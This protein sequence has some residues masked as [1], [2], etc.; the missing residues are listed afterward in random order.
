MDL[1]NK[2]LLAAIAA[3][4]RGGIKDGFPQDH[5]SILAQ[6]N[7]HNVS[8]N[9]INEYLENLSA[10]RDEKTVELDTLNAKLNEKE[11]KIARL[12]SQ[13]QEAQEKFDKDTIDLVAQDEAERERI[14]KQLTDHENSCARE[15]EKLKKEK[16]ALEKKIPLI[17]SEL[18][19][20]SA[21]IEILYEHIKK[22]N[23]ERDPKGTSIGG[24]G[25]RRY[26]RKR[27]KR[28]R[29][30][31]LYSKTA[32]KKRSPIKSSKRSYKNLKKKSR[33]IVFRH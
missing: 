11:G 18:N 12:N 28:Y 13:I 24:G 33:K 5:D 4:R 21:L 29:G 9:A 26:K 8:L 6:I 10:R 27:S 23:T 31:F 19:R 7:A 2:N 3:L 15:I 14:S 20:T 16:T 17:T 32:T 30:G 22:L 25:R 1:V